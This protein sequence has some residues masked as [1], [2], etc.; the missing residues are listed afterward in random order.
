MFPEPAACRTGEALLDM[1]DA[2][3]SRLDEA[4]SLFFAGQNAAAE[5]C[6]SEAVRILAGEE[7]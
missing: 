3:Q 1:L 5:R 6:V 4:E 2:A 7:L